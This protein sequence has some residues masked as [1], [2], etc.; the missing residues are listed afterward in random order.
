MFSS[1]DFTTLIHNKLKSS[2]P[3]VWVRCWCE[4]TQRFK[5]TAITGWRQNLAFEVWT[6]G[7][8]KTVKKESVMKFVRFDFFFQ[9]THCWNTHENFSCC[10]FSVFSSWFVTDWFV[11][12]LFFYAFNFF[13]LV[14]KFRID[15]FYLPK[16]SA[17][18]L[19][20]FVGLVGENLTH[21]NEI[22]SFFHTENLDSWMH[23]WLIFFKWL[24]DEQWCLTVVL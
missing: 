8:C 4:T 9:W 17:R 18:G 15:V 19:R 24:Q 23:N 21:Q 16:T 22:S 14:I 7:N 10:C 11:S 20:R 5:H 6:R 3:T 13:Q 12:H 2:A 1:E